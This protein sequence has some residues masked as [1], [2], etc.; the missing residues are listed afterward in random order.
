M[1]R[2][3]KLNV[4]AEGVESE[5]QYYLLLN[6]DCTHYQGYLFGKPVPIV[7]FEALLE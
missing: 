4:I 6:N 5:E 2:T 3:L 1:A 7:E